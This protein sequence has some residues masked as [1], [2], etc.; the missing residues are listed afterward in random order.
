[1]GVVGIGQDITDLRMQQRHADAVAAE[2]GGLIENANAPIIRVDTNM[3]I[4]W[5]NKHTV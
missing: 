1:M 4:N 2:L 5:W 3:R